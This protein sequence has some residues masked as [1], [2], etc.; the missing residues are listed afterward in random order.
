[1]GN[2]GAEVKNR[3]HARVRTTISEGRLFL[4]DHDTTEHRIRDQAAAVSEPLWWEI[5]GIHLMQ[6]G[7]RSLYEHGRSGKRETVYGN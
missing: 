4:F 6:H 7:I 3:E 1:M 2:P 5:E